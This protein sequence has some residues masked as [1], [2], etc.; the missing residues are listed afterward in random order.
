[1]RPFL[2]FVVVICMAGWITFLVTAFI[3][4]GVWAIPLILALI[5]LMYA[6]VF[7]YA[8]PHRHS[9]ANAVAHPESD[10]SGS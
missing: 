5:C 7:G 8:H 10:I 6:L 9:D 2:L 1:M 4:L 3:V